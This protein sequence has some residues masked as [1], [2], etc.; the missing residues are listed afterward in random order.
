M[1]PKFRKSFLPIAT[2]VFGKEEK[3]EIIDT[4]NSGWI[5]LGPRT[6]RFE[7]MLANYVGSKYAIALNSC[8]AAL[9][10]S[11]LASGIKK[12]DEVITT[13]FTFAATTNAILHCGAKPVFVD[14]D[15]KTFNIDPHK[16]EKAITKKTKAILPVHYAGQSVNLAKIRSIARKHKLPIVE[17]A[18]HALGAKYK[19][20]MIGTLSDLTCFSF[21]PVKNI[22]TGDG[23]AITTN[24]KRFADK[25]RVL[26]VN[27]MA[28]ESWK[29]VTSSGSWDYA[30]V[31]EGYKYHMNDIAAALGIH[32]LNKLNKFINKRRQIADTYDS[33]FKNIEE[34]EIPFRDTDTT[35]HAHNLY[36]LL[37]NTSLLKINRNQIMDILKSQNIGTVVY[38]RPLHTQPYFKNLL[39]YKKGD[40]PKAE[41]VFERLICIPIWAGMTKKD[42]K[43]VASVL[44]S[45]IEENKS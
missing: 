25:L 3:K 16:I 39:G 20:K 10:L 18:A 35:R 13:P 27:G 34:V 43:H 14:I 5:T 12:G 11:M 17:D 32:Q 38:Y 37:I 45:V 1:K 15:P 36:P 42:A 6:K 33:E 23:G 40:F 2:S 44:R 41:Y 4:L 29:R 26:R 22:T 19:R 24:N 21:H 9:H 7:K 31:D 28:K 8:S 30:I